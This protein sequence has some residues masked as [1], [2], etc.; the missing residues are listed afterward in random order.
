MSARR[1]RK[2]LK[3]EERLQKLISE[4]GLA[5]RRA[6]EGLIAEGRVTVNGLAARLGM[7]A[8]PLRDDIRVDGRPLAGRGR[9]VYIMLNKPRGYV[10]TLSD[11]RGRRTVAELVEGCGERVYPVGR[12]DANSEGLLIL[13]NDGELAHVLT[14]PSRGVE[15]TYSVRVAGEDVRASLKKLGGE[16]LL[17][18]GPARAL[19]VRLVSDEGERAI[20]LITVA[21]GRKHL[22]RNLCAAA[23]LEVKRLIRVSEGGLELGGLRTGK[24]RF[25]GE[26]EVEALKKH[27]K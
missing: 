15:K 23:G 14:H 1:A 26:D 7:K 6:A 10:C 3:V 22:V 24:W 12:L 8:D 25:L 18:D 19:R 27:A 21:E 9:R 17:E 5:S 16:L 20:V 2:E 11:E 4:R 13:T